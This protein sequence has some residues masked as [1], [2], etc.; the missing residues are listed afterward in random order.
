M[1]GFL[2]FLGKS[3]PCVESEILKGKNN[4]LCVDFCQAAETARLWVPHVWCVIIP[5]IVCAC[6]VQEGHCVSS[7]E[8][9]RKQKLN[10]FFL[11][12]RLCDS[13]LQFCLT[14]TFV[15]FFFGQF[16]LLLLFSGWEW[17]G[18]GTWCCWVSLIQCGVQRKQH[19]IMLNWQPPEL[20]TYFTCLFALLLFSWLCPGL[21]SPNVDFW[22]STENKSIIQHQHVESDM[23]PLETENCWTQEAQNQSVHC[24][25]V[26]PPKEHSL[27]VSAAVFC[28]PHPVDT[29]C[30]AFR[31]CQNIYK[32]NTFRRTYWGLTEIPKDILPHAKRVV[33]DHNQIT[34]LSPGDL[35]TLGNCYNLELRYNLISTINPG[36]FTGLNSLHKLNLESNKL[37]TIPSGTFI[38]LHSLERLDLDQNQLSSLEKDSFSGL[39]S[40]QELN[41]ALNMFTTLLPEPF[42]NLPRPL[43]LSLGRSN[44]QWNCHSLCWLKIEERFQTLIWIYVDQSVPTCW[45]NLDSTECQHN[46][47]CSPWLQTFHQKK[48]FKWLPFAA[49][50]IWSNGSGGAQKTI[51]NVSSRWLSR[52]RRAAF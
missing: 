9:I 35:I 19:Q 51:K 28:L 2:L 30:M 16:V 33:L 37:T 14:L 26:I 24:I 21:S 4:P 10:S 41:L 31:L 45:K 7:T 47:L 8:N 20:D 12:Q 50:I 39:Y 52:T 17:I 27:C 49:C 18:C 22:H 38:G 6:I 43:G 48:S 11:Y 32:G 15:S 42:L 46:G 29:L 13:R 3:Q 1:T 36:T 5:D 44:G 34:S 23:S 25:Q 40:L